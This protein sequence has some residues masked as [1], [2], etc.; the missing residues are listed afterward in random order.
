[1]RNTMD[2]IMK[3]TSNSNFTYYLV[4]GDTEGHDAVNEIKRLFPILIVGLLF[5]GILNSKP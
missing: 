3:N 1:M 4:Q 5:T 2:N